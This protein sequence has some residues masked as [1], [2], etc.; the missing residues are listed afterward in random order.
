MLLV[1]VGALGLVKGRLGGGLAVV[2]LETTGDT[3]SGVGD[4]LL[5][6][7]LGGLGRVRSD[8][9]LSLCKRSLAKYSNHLK[10]S[11]SCCCRRLG[12]KGHILWLKSL[13]PV[14]DMF[15]VVVF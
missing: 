1:V 2:G 13:R 9:L 12:T 8:L 3:V 4:G 15:A 7:V 11:S 5:D 10:K 6:L 14:S